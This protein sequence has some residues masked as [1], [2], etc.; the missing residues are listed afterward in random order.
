M[1]VLQ[2]RSYP[3]HATLELSKPI[4]LFDADL[5]SPATSKSKY[6]GISVET[7][8]VLFVSAPSDPTPPS[9]IASSVHETIGAGRLP[10]SF[11]ITN[12][13]YI[14]DGAGFGQDNGRATG[15]D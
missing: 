10:Q 4:S 12:K 1:F 15:G 9:I 2:S 14:G 8:T 13:K 3:D 5:R 6:R 11:R 7:A